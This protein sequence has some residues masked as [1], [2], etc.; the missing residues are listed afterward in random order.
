[1]KLKVLNLLFIVCIIAKANDGLIHQVKTHEIE[2]SSLQSLT[3]NQGMY[4]NKIPNEKFADSVT[5]VC[6]TS[7]GVKL[8]QNETGADLTGGHCKPGDNGF[9]MQKNEN[10]SSAE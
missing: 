10:N 8:D 9:V 4:N 3:V 2:I 6:F 1:M 5:E 7:Q